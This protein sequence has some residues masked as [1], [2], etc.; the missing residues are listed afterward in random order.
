M[1]V[2]GGVVAFLRPLLG[3]A[4]IAGNLASTEHLL[5]CVQSYA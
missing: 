4:Q 5:S 3:G 1:N 2:V